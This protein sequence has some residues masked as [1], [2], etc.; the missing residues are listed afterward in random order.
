MTMQLNWDVL[1]LGQCCITSTETVGT[2]VLG[3]WSSRRPLDFHT[4]PAADWDIPVHASPTAT[5]P[6]V[7]PHSKPRFPGH[8]PPNSART[9][10][11]TERALSVSPPTL[12]VPS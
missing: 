6:G 5:V 11:A 4:V 1:R 10:Y 9:G 2:I 12:S 7:L 8:L 3:T